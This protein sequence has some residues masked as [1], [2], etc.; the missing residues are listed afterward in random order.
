[1]QS[2]VQYLCFTIGRPA[3]FL[4]Q[5]PQYNINL[6]ETASIKCSAIGYNVR[7]QW[8]IESGSFPSKV[9]GKNSDTLV[10]S[11]VRSSDKNT[12]TC[13]ATS[14][15]GCVSSSTV[16]LIVTGMTSSKYCGNL[17]SNY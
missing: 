14:W 10:I 8:L 12:Y 5:P 7:Y 11:N 2:H 3:V 4:S 6:T 15:S 17:R 13:L 16:Q 1:M 9:I